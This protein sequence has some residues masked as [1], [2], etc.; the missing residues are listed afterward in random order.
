MEATP[1]AFQLGPEFWTTRTMAL[2]GTVLFAAYGVFGLRVEWAHGGDYASGAVG[3]LVVY[4]AVGAIFG[5]A[6]A[7]FLPAKR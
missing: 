4:A 1:K 2:L 6:M 7:R 5:A 3:S